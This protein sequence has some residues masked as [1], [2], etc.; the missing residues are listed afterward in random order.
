MENLTEVATDRGMGKEQIRDIVKTFLKELAVPF[1]FDASNK[2]FTDACCENMAAR[3]WS[4]E[5]ISILQPYLSAGV[6]I[7]RTAY[8]HLPNMDTKV[9]IAIYTAIITCLDDICTEHIEELRSFSKV[10]CQRG[11]HKFDL[12]N[13][14][15][16]I[17]D[18]IPQHFNENG[19][20]FILTSTFCY[21]N[22]LLLENEVQHGL[23]L[24]PTDSTRF[25]VY[26]RMLSGLP[27]AYALFAFPKEMPW[28]T[29]IQ[30]LPEMFQIVNYGNDLLSIYK[31]ELSGE[32]N[33]VISLLAACKN[34]SKFQIA[35]ELKDETIAS[36][37]AAFNLLKSDGEAL[38]CYEGFRAGYV[39]FHTALPRYKLFELLY[40]PNV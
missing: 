31:E 2:A 3:D 22:A 27:E 15:S 11:V 4:T 18:G 35:Q 24:K 30:A 40:G 25:P 10:H 29:Y 26:T 21:M 36:D 5:T 28:T 38:S 34:V 33:N 19:S 23:E 9:F 37:K 14:F 1:V 6:V 39:A 13:A 16:Q 32:K 7:S 12:L 17:C 8:K 20:G